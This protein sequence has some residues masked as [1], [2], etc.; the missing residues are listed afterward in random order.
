MPNKNIPKVLHFIWIG[1]G[2]TDYLYTLKKWRELHPHPEYIINFWIAPK[3]LTQ[4]EK[5]SLIKINLEKKF[6]LKFRNIEKETDLKNYPLI[7]SE[8]DKGNPWSASDILRLAILVKEPGFYFDLDITPKKTLPDRVS[9]KK[10]VLFNIF[11]E[12]RRILFHFD[13]IAAATE[14]QPVL[15]Y[16]SRLLLKTLNFIKEEETQI[17]IDLA[18]HFQEKSAVDYLFASNCTGQSAAMALFHYYSLPKNITVVDDL[19]FPYIH[20]FE[21]LPIQKLVK[22]FRWS[23]KYKG[24][25]EKVANFNKKYFE[26]YDQVSQGK[27]IEPTSL[28]TRLNKFCAA[29]G[30][31][32]SSVLSN[33]DVYASA[34]L[35]NDNQK[36]QAAALKQG[37][38]DGFSIQFGGNN[39]FILPKLNSEEVSI[40]LKN[41]LTQSN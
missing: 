22:Y 27:E 11:I 39:F 38:N 31:F 21:E 24:L 14:N 23:E 12:N 32:F 28:I 34:K 1:K 13:I 40:K 2:A 4:A 36:Q 35:E 25:K 6:N 33:N 18:Y 20:L 16:I 19:T 26:I 9:C 3:D 7:M 37:M 17:K 8:I 15:E 5:R 29:S 30:L 10:G 41:F